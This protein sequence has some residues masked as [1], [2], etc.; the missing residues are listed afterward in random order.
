MMPT[1]ALYIIVLCFV[2]IAEMALTFSTQKNVLMKIPRHSL[3]V[4]P[5][6]NIILKSKFTHIRPKMC[7]EGK[8][9]DKGDV[10]GRVEENFFGKVVW[11]AAEALG[12]GLSTVT[13]ARSS[14]DRA[15]PPSYT[16][17]KDEIMSRLAAE[18]DNEYF[19]TGQ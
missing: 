18:Y 8:D 2:L 3:I 19:V 17:G 16:M 14:G 12:N 15:T 5:R 13:K 4:A 6:R 9:V 7:S 11:S 1:R 10:V